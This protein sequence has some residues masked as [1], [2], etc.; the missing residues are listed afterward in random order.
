MTIQVKQEPTRGRASQVGERRSNEDTSLATFAY[1]VLGFVA[2][3]LIL[4]VLTPELRIKVVAGTFAGL[5]I[6]LIVRHAAHKRGQVKL[7][8]TALVSSITSGALLG[9]ILAIPVGI[10]F[11]IAL[12]RRAEQNASLPREPIP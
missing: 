2:F 8:R 1:A 3:W 6:G 9:L 5:M 7:G 4:L 11:Y 12:L 10:G